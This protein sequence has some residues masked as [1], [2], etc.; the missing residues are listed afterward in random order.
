MSESQQTRAQQLIG[1]FAPKLVELTDGV[2]FGDIWEREELSP[3]GAKP[4]HRCQLDHQ[5]QHR[6]TSRTPLQGTDQRTD[7]DRTQR[8][9]H[10]FGLLR[11]LAQSHVCHQSRERG[12][13]RRLNPVV[14]KASGAS[15]RSFLGSSQSAVPATRRRLA[16]WGIQNGQPELQRAH[17]TKQ[18][19]LQGGLP[20]WPPIT[21]HRGRC[22]KRNWHCLWPS[23]HLP[24]ALHVRTRLTWTKGSWLTPSNFP[25]LTFPARN[26]RL[27]SSPFRTTSSRVC[28]ASWSTTAANSQ[29]K[30]T[31]RSTAQN[32]KA[33]RSRQ[34]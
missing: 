21:T 30:P 32:V 25:A 27:R 15:H 23:W 4:G 12:I 2:L 1:D 34:Y 9:N 31:G 33:S 11:R 5:W 10:P 18:A 14:C 8:G 20:L 7:R 3:P 26:F 16:A 28:P 19:L 22:P 17:I 24:R 29:G 13:R 6:A